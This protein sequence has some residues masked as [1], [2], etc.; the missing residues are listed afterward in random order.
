M[1]GRPRVT[2][3]RVWKFHTGKVVKVDDVH[4]GVVYFHD[5]ESSR[6]SDH[7]DVNQFVEKTCPVD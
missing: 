1:A 5:E 4:R 2:R 6:G 3:G 7:L